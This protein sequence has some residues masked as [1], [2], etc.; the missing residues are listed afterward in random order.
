MYPHQYGISALCVGKIFIRNGVVHCNWEKKNKNLLAPLF[1]YRYIEVAFWLSKKETNKN[2]IAKRHLNHR[3]RLSFTPV[4]WFL[5][6]HNSLRTGRYAVKMNAEHLEP[7]NAITKKFLNSWD[8]MKKKC[9][10]LHWDQKMS[11]LPSLSQQTSFPRLSSLI[12]ND[13]AL[14]VFCLKVFSL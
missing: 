1:P 2:S 12:I 11:K 4:F 6:F 5:I 8:I 3:S 7:I 14:W 10:S 13:W 9:I